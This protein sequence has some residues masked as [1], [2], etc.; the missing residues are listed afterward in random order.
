MHL[1]LI[2]DK[3]IAFPLP[4]N[5]QDYKSVR[6]WHCN[7]KS[8]KELKSFS[9]LKSLEIA[10]M[11]D[12]NLD[13]LVGMPRL[14]TLRILH[15][16]HVKD[17]TILSKLSSLKHIVLETLPSWDS[18]GKRIIVDSFAPLCGLQSL[19]TLTL[20]GVTPADN[21]YQCLAGCLA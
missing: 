15:M 2:R 4:D 8:L 18:S 20:Y 12:D 5:P 19:F 3:S 6:I 7:Y 13:F 16:P 11:V 9:N 10:T 14:E 1:E 17:L 21:N